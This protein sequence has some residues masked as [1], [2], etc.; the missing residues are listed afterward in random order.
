MSNE[1]N[2]LVIGVDLKLVLMSLP[3]ATRSLP[4]TCPILL[5]P[6]SLLLTR[7]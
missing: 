1:L 6:Y 7:S 5:T 4:R 2:A 3:T